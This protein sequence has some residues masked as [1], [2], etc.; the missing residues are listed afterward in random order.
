MEDVDSDSD[1][2]KNKKKPPNR[3]ES[4]VNTPMPPPHVMDEANKGLKKKLDKQIQQQDSR[5]SRIIPKSDMESALENMN[6]SDE[7]SK[8][9]A[10]TIFSRDQEYF[11]YV[12]QELVESIGWLKSSRT[13]SISSLD[14][15]GIVS[16]LLT[17]GEK[18]SNSSILEVK[19]CSRND[20]ELGYNMD[21]M[22]T[23]KRLILVDT[24]DDVVNSISGD[25]NGNFPKSSNLRLFS[26][27]YFSLLFRP[28]RISDV[29]D[30]NINFRYG[31]ENQKKLESG[32]GVTL[33]LCGW[34]LGAIS[35]T[36]IFSFIDVPVLGLFLSCLVPVLMLFFPIKWKIKGSPIYLTQMREINI[37]IV[38]SHT[39]IIE[40]L[41][42]EV[43]DDQPIES[44]LEWIE[45]L[46][47]LSSMT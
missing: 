47:S 12:K 26:R 37:T 23:N 36:S 42:I 45:N 27:N 14:S 1:F 8:R 21:F 25:Y 46:Q 32:W 28:F 2:K 38:N 40:I 4:S 43:S 35:F 3:E 20:L 33:L 17:K 5:A 19:S 16:R 39:K 7:K 10:T 11:R 34:I 44:V 15:E 41:K 24:D 9:I 29:T 30:I 6:L 22:L 13:Q 31:S 18:F